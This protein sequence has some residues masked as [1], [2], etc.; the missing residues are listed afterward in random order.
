[1]VQSSQVDFLERHLKG[2]NLEI[3]GVLFTKN[4]KVID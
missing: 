1:M 4:E 3:S 2:K